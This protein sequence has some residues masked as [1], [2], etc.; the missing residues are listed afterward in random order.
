M[1]IEVLKFCTILLFR[2]DIKNHINGLCQTINLKSFTK[3]LTTSYATESLLWWIIAAPSSSSLDSGNTPHAVSMWSGLSSSR[4]FRIDNLCTFHSTTQK[5][6]V[7]AMHNI[8][9]I[10]N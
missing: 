7:P 9:R 8:T 2:S 5:A 3:N 6:I 1:Q 10:N 4:R